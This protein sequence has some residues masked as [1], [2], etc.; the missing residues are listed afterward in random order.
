M[1]NSY[2]RWVEY[3]ESQNSSIWYICTSWQNLKVRYDPYLSK[4]N[5]LQKYLLEIF[6]CISQNTLTIIKQAYH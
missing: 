4:I 1:S 2:M 3:G 5:S 6:S